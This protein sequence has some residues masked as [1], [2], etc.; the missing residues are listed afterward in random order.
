MKFPRGNTS[1]SAPK[2]RPD[3]M[4]LR[5]VLPL[6]L[7]FV[8]VGVLLIWLN[9]Q[10]VI[11]A[12]Y[13]LAAVLALYGGFLI[14]S[15]IRSSVTQRIA[16]R[17]LAIG[18]LLTATGILLALQPSSLD[19]LLPKIWG[20]ALIF[21][22]FLKI[23]Y[24]VDEWCVH[25]KRWWIMLIFAGVSLVIGILSLMGTRVFTADNQNLFIGIFMLCEAALD[26]VTYFVINGG[27][28]RQNIAKGTPAPAPAPQVSEPA[29]KPEDTQAP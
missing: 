11:I 29:P 28:K 4:S 9:E 10:V 8:I 27:V 7:F 20:L 25:V 6:I 19:Q 2:K 13:V 18:L 21:G 17:D 26:L 15:Y 12:T 5:Y 22:G 1:G 16:G 23:Q 3:K 24:G 14:Y